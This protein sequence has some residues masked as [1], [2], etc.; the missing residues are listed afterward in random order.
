MRTGTGYLFGLNSGSVWVGLLLLVPGS[1]LDFLPSNRLDSRRYHLMV[2]PLLAFT[3]GSGYFRTQLLL[4]AL[5]IYYDL[6]FVWKC[7]FQLLF[8]QIYFDLCYLSIQFSIHSFELQ[9][10]FI[11]H[12][13]AFIKILFYWNLCFWGEFQPWKSLFGFRFWIALNQISNFG[14]YFPI[15]F[16]IYWNWLVIFACYHSIFRC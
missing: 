5:F 8:F 12:N 13:L 1:Y 11:C 9:L 4:Y 6:I 7:I 10:H 16:S 14:R 2:P 3:T 15:S